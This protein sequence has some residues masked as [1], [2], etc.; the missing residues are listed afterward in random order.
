MT[1]LIIYL[2]I[3]NIVTFAAF[4]SDKDSAR[5]GEWRTP[6]KHLWLL[7]ALGGSPGALLA[8]QVFRHKRKK[9]SFLGPVYFI[10]ACQ[11]GVVGYFAF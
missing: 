11:L 4:G 8:M 2:V 9:Q 3:I 1:F 7:A 5:K 10:I 6:E